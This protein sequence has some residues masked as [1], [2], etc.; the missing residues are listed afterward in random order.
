MLLLLNTSCFLFRVRETCNL[1][2]FPFWHHIL[3]VS[4]HSTFPFLNFKLQVALL[5]YLMISAETEKRP[6]WLI[7]CRI[8]RFGCSNK[9]TIPCHKPDKWIFVVING[10]WPYFYLILKW[11]DRKRGSEP[12]GNCLLLVAGNYD[13]ELPRWT[14]GISC[15]HIKLMSCLSSLTVPAL[16]DEPEVDEVGDQ[17]VT[18]ISNL[19]STS[20]KNF[21]E[22]QNYF[23]RS[24]C[25]F[26]CLNHVLLHKNN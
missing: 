21:N 17:A 11:F 7:F 23:R 4:K 9:R 10:V 20:M 24:S 2:W 19:S 13:K 3:H 12:N 18:D 1:T 15:G 6:L 22:F 8:L 25:S 26:P 5:C 14:R 16:I